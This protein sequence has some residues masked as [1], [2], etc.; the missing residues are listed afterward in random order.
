MTDASNQTMLR[1]PSQRVGRLLSLI[2][3]LA[4]VAVVVTKSVSPVGGC[5]GPRLKALGISDENYQLSGGVYYDVVNGKV[6]RMGSYY[7][8]NGQWTLRIDHVNGVVDEQGLRFSFLGFD[9]VIAPLE[10]NEGGPTSFNRRRLIPF[11]RPSWMP[12]WLE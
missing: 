9:T 5:R 10:G 1:T 11:T 4:S 7:R 3:V 2:I 12:E 8:K 6:N